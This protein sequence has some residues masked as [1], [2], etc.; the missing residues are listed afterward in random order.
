MAVSINNADAL[1]TAGFRLCRLYAWSNY[2]GLG[3]SVQAAPQPPHL[4][5]SIKSNSPA[6]AGGLKIRDVLLGINNQDVSEIKYSDLT[7]MIKDASDNDNNGIELLVVQQMY[8]KSLKKKG[9]L[10]DSNL[11][12][13]FETPKTMPSDYITFP[14]HTPRTCEIHLSTIDESFGIEIIEGENDIGLYIQEVEVNSPAYRTSLR[15]SDRIIEIDDK[16]INNESS[17]MII[18]KL[19]KAKLKRI[20]KLYVVDTNTYKYFQENNIPLSSKEYSQSAFAKKLS[21][22]S[23]INQYESLC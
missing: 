18:R 2:N 5:R 10:F 6:A 11:A 14:K 20:V 21:I 23:Y 7:K 3:F 8:Y 16:F 22:N 12:E 9:V 13:R 1:R 17:E 19:Y 4:I 15:K